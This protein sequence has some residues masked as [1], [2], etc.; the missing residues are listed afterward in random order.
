MI[1]NLTPRPAEKGRIKIGGLGEERKKR[2]GSGTY[3]LP[4]KFDHFEIVTMQRDAAGRFMLDKPLM[5]RLMEHQGVKKLLEIPIRLLFDDPDLNFFTR[6]AAYS[7]TRAWCT[8]D[9]EMAQRLGEGTVNGRNAGPNEFGT[10]SCPCEHLEATYAGPGPKCKPWGNLRCLIEGVDRVGGIW[11]FRTTSYNS[12]NAILSSMALIRTITGGP[13]AGIPLAMTLA[14]KTV[15]TPDGK[16]MVAYIVS[17]EY[18][19]QEEKLAELGYEIAKRRIEHQ[20]RME[21]V[22][23]EAR[24]LLVAP[25]QESPEE[26]AATAAEFYPESTPL[27]SETTS[28]D[29]PGGAK[30][31]APLSSSPGPGED[32]AKGAGTTSEMAETKPS[33]ITIIEYKTITLPNLMEAVKIQGEAQFIFPVTLVTGKGIPIGRWTDLAP[34]LAGEMQVT[35]ELVS[36]LAE[37]ANKLTAE[38]IKKS[39]L[40]AGISLV[41]NEAPAM[42]KMGAE[43]AHERLSTVHDPMT[44]VDPEKGAVKKS[45]F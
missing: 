10:R 13:L 32:L 6:Y 27:A 40:E 2:D 7:G 16:S 20:I 23:V 35:I 28:P 15:A 8:G 29:A 39:F 22:E 24:K 33:T 18:R 31:E 12:V 44:G 5:D 34:N 4:V 11:S 26:Q 14:P 42:D 36:N 45:L 3:M 21:T 43:E 38:M 19:G 9:G 37:V 41:I 25:H 1:R 30:G 17:L